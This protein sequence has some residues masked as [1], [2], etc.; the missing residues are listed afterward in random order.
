MYSLIATEPRKRFAQ[1]HNQP[2]KQA[3]HPHLPHACSHPSYSLNDSHLDCIF[4]QG[5]ERRG[6]PGV[7]QRGQGHGCLPST[8][9]AH[10]RAGDQV[11]HG[12]EHGVLE[13]A[14]VSPMPL[15]CSCRGDEQAIA[16]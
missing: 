15:E 8:Q 10:T 7:L 1:L 13:Q 4:C 2:L 9:V 16:A 5:T 14:Q 6:Q 11:H 12:R 3:F